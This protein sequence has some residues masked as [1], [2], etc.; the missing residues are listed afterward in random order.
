M[1]DDFRQPIADAP[2][3]H[4]G[5]DGTTV[6]P[7]HVRVPGRARLKIPAIHRN[8]E[9]AFAIESHLR[10][11]DGIIS[12]SANGWSGNL[13]VLYQQDRTLDDV[14]EAVRDV[15]AA[16]AACT[17][18]T[19]TER[20]AQPKDLDTSAAQ[21]ADATSWWQRTVDETL[22]VLGTTA[23]DGLSSDEVARRRARYGA[24][25]LAAASGR[26][27]FAILL[28][29]FRS[30][31]TVLLLGSTVLSAVTGGLLDAAL[32]AG[33][34]AINATIGFTTE[35]EA[36]RTIRS[37]ATL[38]HPPVPVRRD[39]ALRELALEDIVPGD[40]LLLPPGTRVAAD[41]RVIASEELAA[42]E[43]ALTGESVPVTKH[44]EAIALPSPPLAERANM[45]FRGTSIASGHGVAVVAATGAATEIG[46]IEALVASAERPQTP[47]Q[48]QLE[49]LG[50]Q[51]SLGSLG[52]CALAFAIGLW[53]GLGAI[54]MLRSAAALA[55]AAIPEGLPTVATT[56]LA[57]G[58]REMQRHNVLVRQLDAV[59]TL[60]AVSVMCF[61]KTGTLTVNR[62]AVT[63]VVADRKLFAFRDGQYILSGAA[64]DPSLHPELMQ[65][66]KIAALCNESEIVSGTTTHE[67]SGS[68]TETALLVA[69]MAAGLDI[70][71]LRAAHPVSTRIYRSETRRFM[72][73]VHIV[74]DGA[75][76]AVKG[77]PGDVLALCRWQLRD[78]RRKRLGKAR[79]ATIE[80]ANEQMASQGLRVLGF[81]YA[82]IGRDQEPETKDLVWLGLMAMADPTR[83]GMRELMQSFH[84]AGIRTV[85]ITG[86]QSATAYAVGKE[87][88]LSQAEAMEV[89]D[90]PK[91]DSASSEALAAVLPRVD[92]FART[93]PAHKLEIVRALQQ[94]DRVV[95]MTGDGIN[96]GPALRV[97]DIGVA[98]GRGGTEAAREIADVVL[99]DD[100]LRT[101]IVAVEHGRTIY[102]NIRKSVHFQ[103]ATNGGELVVCITALAV[104]AGQPLG[105]VQLL[106]LNLVNDVLPALALG[107]EPPESDVMALP[108]RK[109]SRPIIDAQ[110][111]H[112]IAVESGVIGGSALLAH[113]YG[114]ARYGA[115]GGGI[116]LSSLT[117][118]QLLHAIS[119]RSEGSVV[120]AQRRLPPNPRFNYAIGGLIALQ[121]LVTALPPTR[122]LLGLVLPTPL[123]AAII[124]AT[125]GLPF[126]FA[127]T[128][129][130]VRQYAR[131][132]PEESNDA[133]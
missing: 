15:V 26:S 95:A 93:T 75:L 122:R 108:P 64:A 106:W 54:E 43:S 73:T 127:E 112:R 100:E 90:G 22:A 57:L 101:M 1:M 4:A 66:L 132:A 25:L 23:A 114:V 53:R 120:F 128:A 133:R 6:L 2:P 12:A 102:R 126:L 44:A 63:G 18:T 87:L 76:L 103:V 16:T 116:A 56:T 81:A 107:L 117:L 123:D 7:V 36:E 45:V 92:V 110:D 59:E 119:C 47:M 28:D 42:D 20:A 113:L 72:M 19:T 68:P 80:A 131:P 48:Q 46:R 50:R 83:P 31:P 40:V 35:R 13:M 39:G 91:M 8:P 82:P 55:V 98:M 96:D 69:A 67:I 9:A 37:L 21:P 14:L 60:G 99:A 94:A 29:Q 70:A 32:I 17:Q 62:M 11:R 130:L 85:M 124:G 129:K 88:A 118:S 105:P 38:G 109:R 41:A 65:I 61:D 34:V 84:R 33:V 51:L 58:I 86:D 89:L 3:P 115:G 79:R 78:G 52:A 104:G 49:R 97:A 121:A 10:R 77:S 27:D 24:N 125:A 71:A 30:L 74:P 111:Y 5:R